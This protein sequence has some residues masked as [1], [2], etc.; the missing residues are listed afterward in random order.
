[1]T[2]RFIRNRSRDYFRSTIP[3]ALAPRCQGF[4]NTIDFDLNLVVPDQNKSWDDGA[5]EP[6]TKPRYRVLL[7]EAKQW[8]KSQGIPTNV[9][10]RHRSEEHTSELQSRF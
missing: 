5:I 2:E 6:W 4:G 9:P 3:M 1:M 7:N 8:A 10:W